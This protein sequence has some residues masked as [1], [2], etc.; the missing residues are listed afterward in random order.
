MRAEIVCVGTELL[1]G[2]V[3]N[4]DAAFL[5]RELALLGFDLNHTCVVGDNPERLAGALKTALSRSDLV[6]TTGGLGP[7][8]DDLT[9]KTVAEVLGRKLVRFEAA[10][11]HIKTYF[12]ARPYGE[13]QENQTYFPEGATILENHNGTAPGCAI[14]ADNGTLVMLFP[15]PPRELEPMFQ[16]EALP[17]LHK[18]VGASIVSFMVRTFDQGEG[19]A[20]LKLGSLC[21]SANPS[22]ATYLGA[23]NEV[24]VRVT[25]K[26][27]TKEEAEKLALPMVEEVKSRLGDVVYGVNVS[28]LEEVV[29]GLLKERGEEVATA[30]SCTGGMLA[31]RI[32]DVPGS[33]AVFRTGLVTYANETKTCL[34]GVPEDM[35]AKHGAVSEEVARGMAEGVRKE[36]GAD[37]GIGITGIAGPDGGSE[38]KPVGLVYIALATKGAT[39]VFRMWPTGIYRGR[40][41]VRERSVGKA[42]DMLRRHLEGHEVMHTFAP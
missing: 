10:A 8:L 31:K 18:L 22:A 1:L 11:E 15:G 35:L 39:H 41:F 28:S 27:A 24:F 6:I 20:A 9:K 23:H 3:V 7:T 36:S 12:G 25:A 38:E 17:V 34:L 26:A 5:A 30:E 29:V 2:H 21:E 37:H 13:N 32:T 16:N 40:N 14:T 42:L 19:D 33:S 4:T